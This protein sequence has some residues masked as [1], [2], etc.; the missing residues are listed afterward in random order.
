MTCVCGHSDD[1]HELEDDSDT[2]ILDGC[3]A[4]SCEEF[5]EDI[6]KDELEGE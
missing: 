1:V 6:D 3:E 5:E 4:C 2:M